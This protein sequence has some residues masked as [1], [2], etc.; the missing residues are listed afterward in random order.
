M[1]EKRPR[2]PLRSRMGKNSP[3]SRGSKAGPSS[4]N[5]ADDEA[6]FDSVRAPPR[7]FLPPDRPRH[8]SLVARALPGGGRAAQGQ[9]Q[10]GAC[11]HERDGNGRGG[12]RLQRRV[13]PVAGLGAELEERR[14]HAPD[15]E[16][17]VGFQ[18]E[19]RR[20][21]PRARYGA[22]G[23]VHR[24]DEA[25][26]EQGRGASAAKPGAGQ[27]ARARASSRRRLPSSH[28]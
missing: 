9:G 2:A 14:G 25:R 13:Q 17:G 8:A 11:G 1:G 19:P 15:A 18:K 24:A 10:F 5:S 26:K 27:G 28:L 16:S 22:P 12:R 4:S 23:G 3:S 21:P 6:A 7:G 20:P